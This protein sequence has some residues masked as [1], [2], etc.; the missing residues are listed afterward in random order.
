VRDHAAST[1][2]PA[3]ATDLL[4]AQHAG[5]AV[6]LQAASTSCRRQGIEF[7]R[8][9]R[10]TTT[11]EHPGGAGVAFKGTIVCNADHEEIRARRNAVTL[12]AVTVT[13]FRLDLST[14]TGTRLIAVQHIASCALLAAVP[15]YHSGRRSSTLPTHLVS[16]HQLAPAHDSYIFNS[17]TTLLQTQDKA[18]SKVQ[19]TSNGHSTGLACM[20]GCPACRY[21]VLGFGTPKCAQPAAASC[22]AA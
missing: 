21:A 8:T 18:H 19:H 6:K 13:W 14:P 9:H 7:G 17:S 11:Q 1:A 20:L 2:Q 15:Q 12:I 16:A 10:C 3:R 22:N 4:A 5:T